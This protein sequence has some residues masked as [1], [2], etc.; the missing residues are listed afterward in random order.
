MKKNTLRVH[1]WAPILA[2][3]A[4]SAPVSA[5]EHENSRF[6]EITVTATKREQTI[7]EVPVALS[8][9]ETARAISRWI[10]KMSF[11]V[12]L[13]SKDSAQRC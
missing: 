3:V 5:D 8:A 6:E 9:F 4:F 7:Y 1:L 10:P 11:A 2:A 13:R 12:S